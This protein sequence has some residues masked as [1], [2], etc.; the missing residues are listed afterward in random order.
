MSKI[1]NGRLVI[2]KPARRNK[3]GAVRTTFDGLTFDSQKECIRYQELKLLVRIGEIKDLRHH[4]RFS[5]DI[6]GQHICDYEADFTYLDTTTGK[7]VVEDVKS[8]AT[9]TLA[10]YRL[11]K[12]LMK[13][14]LNI[15][16]A[17]V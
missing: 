5:I 12:R 4:E 8:Q 3:F 11:K 1:V 6:D 10:V 2:N 15:D 9:S 14:V 17:E 16:I 7:L 13:V